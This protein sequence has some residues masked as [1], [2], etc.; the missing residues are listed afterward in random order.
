MP[1]RGIDKFLLSLV[2]MVQLSITECADKPTLK[3]L[4]PCLK[5]IFSAMAEYPELHPS[6]KSLLQLVEQ[7]I[8]NVCKTLEA[9]SK[10]LSDKDGST[11]LEDSKSLTLW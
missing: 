2:A 4:L 1:S 5:Q 3:G 7:L 6:L 8:G 9:L 11:L 10:R